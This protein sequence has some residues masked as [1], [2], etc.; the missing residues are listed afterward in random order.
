MNNPFTVS[1][2][3]V[4]I[5]KN[6]IFPGILTVENGKISAIRESEQSRVE[7]QY[8]LPGLIDAHVHIESSML[9]PSEFARIAVKHGTI[10]TVSDPH[11]I[12]N[13]LGKQG[14]EFMIKNGE[15]TPFKF[16]FGAPSCVPA[17]PFE[18]SGAEINLEQIEELLQHPKIKYLAEMMNFPG[19]LKQD[20]QVMEKLRAAKK[21]NK[22]ADGH[23][24]GLKGEK[25]AEYCRAGITTD[26]ECSTLQ[27]AR[28][29]IKAGMKIQIREGSAAKNYETLIP[30][31]HDF[32]G[33]IMFCSDDKH[34]DDLVQGHMNT[35]VKRT[36]EK[37]YDLIT[38]LKPCS[39]TPADHYKLQVGMLQIN[40]P[41]D[42]I[43]IDNPENFRILKTFI[44]GTLLAENGNSFL[45]TQKEETPNRFVTNRL[46]VK[47]IEVDAA[48]GK[49]RVIDVTD[50]ALITGQ[51]L[52]EPT[53]KNGKIISDPER[54]I[55][56][57]VVLNRYQP[58]KPALGFIHNTG[59]KKGAMISTV[60]HDS[61][62]II[63]VGLE[64]EMIIEAIERVS[65][66]KGGIGYL[67]KNERLF[68][69]LPVAGIM[70]NMNA[71]QVAKAYTQIDRLAKKNGTKL[72]AP[73]MTLSFMAL[74]VIPS[75]KISD[76]GLFDA[77]RFAFIDLLATPQG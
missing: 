47:D 75:L 2:M 64:D 5:R 44:N 32:P 14:V 31:L 8:I 56:K 15:K 71:Q 76:K 54:D 18:T 17:T 72:T 30:L 46:S 51:M 62:N 57:I 22:P 25:A 70:S 55:L 66:T 39:S 42:F 33:Q 61:H 52:T 77:N 36:L 43:I 21:H 48:P 28:D 34:P 3:I 49:L 13:V 6:R 63:A 29:K 37:G 65:A 7:A 60:A 24:P 58:S 26:H 19:V 10:G 23:A 68:L 20:K 53:V 1:G 40:D 9:L 45:P 27:E 11:E 41:A 4:D 59:L 12:A 38:A 35:L 50:G 73:F 67:N 69:P 16:Y 74:L